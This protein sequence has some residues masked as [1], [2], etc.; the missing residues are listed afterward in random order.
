MSIDDI[1][2]KLLL[3]YGRRQLKSYESSL[4]MYLNRITVFKRAESIER[5]F[6]TFNY[7]ED[8]I[9]AIIEVLTERG[10]SI[11]AGF[12]NKYNRL[13]EARQQILDRPSP[14]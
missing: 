5:Y 12:L 8:F 6:D 11:P 4:K 7:C 10:E 13:Q 3:N 2:T 9:D 14:C 1:S